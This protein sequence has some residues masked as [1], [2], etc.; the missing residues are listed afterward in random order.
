MKGRLS[1]YV[2]SGKY[3]LYAD[4]IE[5]KGAGALQLAYEQLR[6]QL[7][8]EG[9]FDPARKRPLPMLPRRI[10]IVTSLEGAAVRDMIRVL[11]TRRVPADLVIA[12]TR[13]Q[14]EGAAIEIARAIARIARVPH[15]DVV[16]VGR[17]GGSLEDLWAF[18]EERVAR[19]I[20]ACPVPVISA[21]GHETDTTIAD[22]V[23]DVRAATPSQAA[24]IVVQ[25]GQRVPRPDCQRAPPDGPVAAQPSRSPTDGPACESS[26]DRPSRDFAIA[27]SIATGNE[28]TC[29]I[30]SARRYGHGCS[31]RR[32]ACAT[33][34][35]A[36]TSSTRND[37]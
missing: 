19:A 8:G 15:V 21:V 25:T 1:V 20:A 26:S 35:A 13:V 18:N 4:S 14:G 30:D 11:R 28:S 5:P 6:R 33:S 22:F 34:P 9:L 24:E 23:A 29:T 31:A 10:G 17:G 27:S 3:Q 7:H 12:P 37:S 32:T 2:P 16:I 36:S